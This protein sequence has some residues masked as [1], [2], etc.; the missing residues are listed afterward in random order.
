MSVKETKRILFALLL[1]LSLLALPFLTHATDYD[2]TS[3]TVKDPVID[4]GSETSSSANFGLGQ[5]LSQNAIGKSTSSNF[6]LWS[7]FQYYFQ[8]DPNTLNATAGDSQVSLSWTVPQ[9][10]LGINVASY[11][12]G[13]GTTSGSYVFQNVGNVTS[14]AKTG[15][16]NGVPYYF[17]VKA[18]GPAGIFL[19]Y[20]NEASA[21]PVAATVPPPPPP[22]G[23]G[24][25]SSG[26]ANVIFT[27]TAYPDS[28]VSVVRD[29]VLVATVPTNADGT[30]TADL[31]GMNA[32]TY[33]FSLY[34]TDPDDRT[35]RNVTFL[36]TINRFTTDTIPGVL[37]PPTISASHTEIRQG[38]GLTVR[39]YAQ[40]NAPVTLVFGGQSTFT[41]NVTASA[42]GLYTYVLYTTALAKGDYT[43]Y[44]HAH[45]G[46]VDTPASFTVNFRV[47]DQSTVTPPLGTCRRSDLNCD[48]R[49]NL[50]DFSILLYFWDSTSFSQN[51]RV[52]IDKSGQIGL[53]DLSIMLYDWTG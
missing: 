15:L 1:G 19:V 41:R 33:T 36:R 21:T 8:V 3:Y 27:G 10:F 12:V 38:E 29:S 53:R 4:A 18:L 35:S 44:S 43:V 51:L 13:T 9:T 22:S 34:A 26:T 52:D 14:F 16:T 24:S 50:I 7:G 49:V 28:T 20:S 40:P 39:G 47:G 23:G 30:F 42:T 31:Y 17:I 6:Q 5:S 11:E 25:S 48:G 2:S 45:I 32:G 37:M 46:N